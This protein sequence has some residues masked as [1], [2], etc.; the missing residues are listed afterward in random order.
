[1]L[2][3]L[4]EDHSISLHLLSHPRSPFATTPAFALQ[5]L[6][7]PFED[8]SELCLICFACCYYPAVP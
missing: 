6:P 4:A 7:F 2:T 5:P 1:L 8:Q 3:A